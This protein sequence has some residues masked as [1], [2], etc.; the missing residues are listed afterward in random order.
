ML[1]G[2][3]GKLQSEF[4]SKTP[5]RQA[6]MKECLFTT[7]PGSGAVLYEPKNV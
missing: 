7:S 5:E 2:F 6:R 1:K 3:M 4:Y